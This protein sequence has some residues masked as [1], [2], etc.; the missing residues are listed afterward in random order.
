MS[1]RIV[2]TFSIGMLLAAAG[3]AVWFGFIATGVV[4][5]TAGAS[6]AA[7]SLQGAAAKQAFEVASIRLFDPSAGPG[8]PGMFMNFGPPCGFTGLQIEGTRFAVT[9]FT[10]T[11]IS[12]AYGKP[13]SNCRTPDLLTGG[14]EWIRSDRYDIQAVMPAGSSFTQGQFAQRD[15]PGLQM[16]LQTLLE[17]RFKLKVHRET[18]DITVY[19]LT[20]TKGAKVK[21]SS[22][23][24][25]VARRLTRRMDN[26]QPYTELAAGKATMADLANML[27]GVVGGIVQDKTGLTG[28]FNVNLEFDSNGA[29]R[30]TVFT[31][32]QE[33]GLKLE[34]AKLPM[35]VMVI[36]SIER[37][38]EN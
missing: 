27:G 16:M 24:D 12:I 11:L 29:A 20:A 8:R 9:A 25:Q 28:Q 26:N 19:A 17:E 21:A 31:A 30:P 34:T 38:S 5:A 13:G 22:E 1:N 2:K 14:P 18:K 23:S 7:V 35:E 37:P 3:A 33:I 36:D 4:H 10:Y 6:H 32:L 15:A